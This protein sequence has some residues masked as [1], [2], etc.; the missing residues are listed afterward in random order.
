MPHILVVE[1]DPLV[2]YLVVKALLD[3]GY[4]VTKTRA[5]TEAL[6]TLDRETPDLILSDLH[7]PSLDGFGLF[8]KIKKGYPELPFIAMCPPSLRTRASRYGFDH[9]IHKPFHVQDMLRDVARVVRKT[10]HR[11]QEQRP[12]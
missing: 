5:G 9:V 2:I 8:Q 12:V 3:E 11:Y 7:M 6:R 4:D 1:D 10:A